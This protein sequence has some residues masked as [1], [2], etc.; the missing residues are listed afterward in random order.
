MVWHG[1][2]GLADHTKICFAFLS[3]Q[4]GLAGPDKEIWG[5]KVPRNRTAYSQAR[6]N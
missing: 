6:V 4:Y 5:T 3:A 1:H 2:Y